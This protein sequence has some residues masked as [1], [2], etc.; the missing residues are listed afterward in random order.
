[1]ELADTLAGIVFYPRGKTTMTATTAL[2]RWKQIVRA[3]IVHQIRQKPDRFV[4]TMMRTAETHGVTIDEDEAKFIL[5]ALAGVYTYARENADDDRP[6]PNREMDDYLDYVREMGKDPGNWDFTFDEEALRDA[7]QDVELFDDVD[8]DDDLSTP[9]IEAIAS[10]AW[11]L[12]WIYEDRNTN[13][14]E[15]EVKAELDRVMT[16]EQQA[17]APPAML[18]RIKEVIRAGG[19]PLNPPPPQ[20]DEPDSTRQRKPTG[21]KSDAQVLTLPRPASPTKAVMAIRARQ[22]ED[23]DDARSRRVD[24]EARA[25][26]LYPFVLSLIDAHKRDLEE[27][28]DEGE[29]GEIYDDL[30]RIRRALQYEDVLAIVD[31]LIDAYDPDDL[32]EN[33]DKDQLLALFNW[34]GRLPFSPEQRTMLGGRMGAIPPVRSTTP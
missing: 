26:I 7:M 32:P 21:D 31:E 18:E 20:A 25:E 6:D 2:E 8:L 24:R 14:T 1:M 3:S 23:T 28:T 34:D 22:Q 5:T 12:G 4:N 17:L 13:M 29:R 19:D 15:D 30:R 33:G 27:A 10:Y 11:M 16:P 9:T